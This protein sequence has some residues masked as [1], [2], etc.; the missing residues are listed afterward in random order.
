MGYLKP[1]SK[2][3]HVYI[4]IYNERMFSNKLSQDFKIKEQHK[5]IAND[6]KFKKKGDWKNY[7]TM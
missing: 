2:F 6:I 7:N 3:E 1:C 4:Y 5:N